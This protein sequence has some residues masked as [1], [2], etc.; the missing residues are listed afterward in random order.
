[1]STENRAIMEQAVAHVEQFVLAGAAYAAEQLVELNNSGGDGAPPA[2]KNTGNLR[3]SLRLTVNTPSAEVGVSR[4]S[5]GG[6]YPLTTSRDARR[7]IQLG[8]F[9]IGDV[10]WF[11]WIAPYANIIDLGRG[12]DK[13][14]RPIGSDQAPDGWVQPD[15]DVT[16]AR[17]SRWRWPGAE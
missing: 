11:R 7:A 9:Q 16:V 5:R 4:P 14:G 12:V 17:L 6:S 10:L 2:P 1:V 13:N 8:G 15:V 3:G